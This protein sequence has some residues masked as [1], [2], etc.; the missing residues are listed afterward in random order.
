PPS[1]YQTGAPYFL[2]A[3]LPLCRGGL[4]WTVGCMALN[5]VRA[6]S[7]GRGAKGVPRITVI[8]DCNAGMDIAPES[9]RSSA[10]DAGPFLLANAVGHCCATGLGVQVL[11]GDLLRSGGRASI[12]M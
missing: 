12:R 10:G 5:T 1:T 3:A 11:D 9:P 4:R 2:Q 8:N 6:V 7:G